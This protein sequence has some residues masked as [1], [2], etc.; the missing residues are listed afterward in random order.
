MDTVFSAAPVSFRNFPNSG[1]CATLLC[2]HG[3][4]GPSPGP[5]SR[6]RGPALWRSIVLNLGGGKQ[7]WLS[8]SC[9]VIN[10]NNN[11]K[12]HL[13]YKMSTHYIMTEQ[14]T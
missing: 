6:G 2:D 1:V 11:K 14:G 4:G 12:K 3:Q 9:I 8:H 5:A 13:L 10:I 7:S